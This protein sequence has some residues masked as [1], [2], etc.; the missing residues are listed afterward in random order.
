MKSYPFSVCKSNALPTWKDLFKLS[1][2]GCRTDFIEKISSIDFALC[3]G[4]R[5]LQS[6]V[7]RLNLPLHGLYGVHNPFRKIGLPQGK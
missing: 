1:T 4:R 5:K 7:F 2:K 6:K 3:T